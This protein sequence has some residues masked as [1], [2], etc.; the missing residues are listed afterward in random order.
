MNAGRD[1][2]PILRSA[3]TRRPNY[4]RVN[5]GRLLSPRRLLATGLMLFGVTAVLAILAWVAPSKRYIILPDAA[6][7][8]SPLVQVAGARPTHGPGGVYFVDV[9]V[10]KATVLERFFPGLRDGSTL[11]PASA[12]NQG[13]SNRTREQLDRLDMARSQEV[14][15]AVAFRALGYHIGS[16]AQGALIAAVFDGT[17]A[18]GKLHAGDVIVAVDGR[19]VK[20]RAALRRLI[21]VRRAGQ[22]VRLRVREGRQTNTVDLKTMRDPTTGRAVIGVYVG[23]AANLVLPRRVKIDIGNV[24]GPSAGLAFALAVMDKLGRDVDRGYRVA[25]TGALELNGAVD[26]I[27][28]VKQK[29]IG[30]RRSHVDL[31]LVPAGDN[32]RE[33]RRYANGL[34]V[35]P[36]QTFRQALRVLATLPLKR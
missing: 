13:V 33:A 14:A 16:H 34:R 5:V 26:P 23:E 32:A 4:A 28:G 2:Q 31:F 19:P 6:H 7:P 11:V 29:T 27:G 12:V 25:A 22:R 9:I 3:V 1:R 15:A 24:V 36:V 8:V 30:A 35:V 20:T 17:P 21:G 10:R 18:A